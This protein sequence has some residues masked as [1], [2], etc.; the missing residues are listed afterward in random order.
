MCACVRVCL[1]TCVHVC[2]CACESEGN[3]ERERERE[4]DC[5]FMYE[6]GRKADNPK[7]IKDNEKSHSSK[8]HATGDES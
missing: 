4:R 7:T 1:G 2:V 8:R 5:V 3:R 6:R